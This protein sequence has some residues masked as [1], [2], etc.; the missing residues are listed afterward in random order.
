V[1]FGFAQ[2]ETGN[3]KVLSEFSRSLLS[4]GI[5]IEQG[6]LVVLDVANG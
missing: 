4:R 5:Q 3:E 1:F 6:V 2:A